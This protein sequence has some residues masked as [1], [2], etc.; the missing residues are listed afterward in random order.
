[1]LSQRS[2]KLPHFFSFFLFFL[3]FQWQ[4]FLLFCLIHCSVSFSLLNSFGVYFS[5]QLLCSSSLFDCSYIFQL[6]VKHCVPVFSNSLVISRIAT[7]E[8]FLVDCLFPLYFQFFWNFIFISLSGTY[9]SLA[10]FV[11]VAILFLCI[12]FSILFY[13]FLCTLVMFLNLVEVT[14]RRDI[15]CVLAAYSP[16]LS[17][18]LYVEGFLIWGLVCPYL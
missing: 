15:L 18:K 4:W 1:M 2:F 14:F 9:S 12:H 5:F 7:L 6:F 3:L 13:V 8:S 16:L 11:Q 10:H 17:P